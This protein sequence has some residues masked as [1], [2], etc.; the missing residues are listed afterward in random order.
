MVTVGAGF[1]LIV[2]AS[3]DVFDPPHPIALSASSAAPSAM[4]R[5][6]AGR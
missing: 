6:R 5:G 4:T 3:G 2:I 1:L